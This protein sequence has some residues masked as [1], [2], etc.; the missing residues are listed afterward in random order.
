MFYGSFATLIWKCGTQQNR[1][2]IYQP[3]GDDVV[4]NWED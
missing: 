1:D 4:K 3:I 2:A